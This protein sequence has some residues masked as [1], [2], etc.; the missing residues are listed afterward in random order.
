MAEER[1]VCTPMMLPQD[2]WVAA[3][4]TAATI[5]PLN[6]APLE[7]LMMVMPGFVPQPLHLAIMVTKYW[8]ASGIRLTVGFLDNPPADLRAR[9]LTH[10]NAWSKTANIKFVETATDPQVRISRTPG[11][12]VPG[13]YWSYVGTDIQHIPADK[14]TMMLEGFTMNTIDSEFY[15]VVRHETGHTIGCP[16][17]HMRKEL[18]DQID[19][20]KAIAYFWAN[21]GWDAEMVKQQVLTPI[22]D[23]SLWGTA[24]ADPYS[25]MCY[26]L[27]G[28]ITKSGVPIVGGADISDLDY[29]FI[30]QVY[31]LPKAVV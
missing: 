21:D 29:S 2:Q 15:R 10:M 13:G 27:P 26:Q 3:A 25:I 1:K 12:D 17:E 19:P 24:H 8:G 28:T 18:V 14:P 16:H 9:L 6:H 20:N 5:N 30:G 11:G 7:R 4:R 31:P 22:E 23:S